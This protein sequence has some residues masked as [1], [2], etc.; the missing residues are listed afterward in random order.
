MSLGH[1]DADLAV[2][3]SLDSIAVACRTHGVSKLWVYG[4]ILERSPTSD[5]EIRFLVDFL[6][7]DF[8]PWGSKLDLLENDLSG[9]LHRK[10]FVASRGGIVDSTPSPFREE[11]LNSARLIYES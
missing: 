2:R 6:N 5:D 11:I 1:I 10:V 7:D 4:P 9:S 3:L 8:G